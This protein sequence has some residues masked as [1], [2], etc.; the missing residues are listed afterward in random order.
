MCFRKLIVN[1]TITLSGSFSFQGDRAAQQWIDGSPYAFQMW[2]S[3]DPHARGKIYTT[4]IFT[5]NNSHSWW[6]YEAAISR[7]NNHYIEPDPAY[8]C[9][10]AQ[11]DA[12]GIVK[13][14]KLPCDFSLE[15]SAHFCELKVNLNKHRSLK[16]WKYKE[17]RRQCPPR[18]IKLL[19]SCI[20]IYTLPSSSKINLATFCTV[21]GGKLYNMPNFLESKQP[22]DWNNYEN[23]II[24]VLQAMNH[25]WPIFPHYTETSKDQ[26]IAV[27]ENSTKPVVLQFSHTALSQVEIVD[28]HTALKSGGIHVA[29][30]FPLLL[31]NS[32]CLTG[33]FACFDGT[34]IL[35][36]YVCDGVND[37]PD[38]SD[39]TDCEY[40]CSFFDIASGEK[41][42]CFASCF[43][44]NCICTDLY[45]QCPS[46]GCVPWSRICDGTD[47]CPSAE[48]EQ[49][50]EFNFMD[51]PN[52]QTIVQKRDGLHISGRREIK[53]EKYKCQDNK[54][55]LVTMLNDLVP[56]CLD[57]VDE[58][59]FYNFLINGSQTTYSADPS[60]C[61]K[62]D[63]TTCV[64]NYPDVCYPR[65]LHCV[66]ELR[67]S[68]A[69]GCRNAGHMLNCEHHDCPSQFKCPGAYC[70]P[71]HNVCDG[72]QDCPNGEDEVQCHNISC[73]GL[74]L[75]RHDNVCVHPYDIWQGHVKCPKSE[76][77]KALR[78][79]R[80][81]SPCICLGYAMLCESSKLEYLPK[82]SMCLRVLV[83]K[84]IPINMNNIKFQES[85]FVFLLR[86]RITNASVARLE[87]RHIDRLT[88]L[89]NLNLSHNSILRLNPGTFKTLT[90]LLSIDLSFNA[91]SILQSHM[92]D[93]AQMVTHLTLANN[94]IRLIS[95]RT[96]QSLSQLQQLK[97]S[98]NK[99]T[100]LG[101]NI[102]CS[103]SLKVV[104]ISYN[105]FSKIDED[106]LIG[107]FQHLKVLNTS[108]RRI[109]CGVSSGLHCYPK[110]VLS[111]ISS[112]SHLVASITTRAILWFVGAAL[113]PLLGIC[114]AWFVYQIR[115][116][117]NNLYNILSSLNFG[118]NLYICVYCFIISFVDHV[119]KG[120]YFFF[121][122]V[123]RQ[124]TACILLNCLSYSFFQTMA[125]LCT[126]ISCIRTIAILYPFKAPEISV[127]GT[128]IAV[129]LWF[130]I[131]IIVSYSCLTWVWPG[132]YKISETAVGLA[133]V[134]PG[135]GHE[136]VNVQWH[137]LLFIVPSVLVLFCF[138]CTQGIGIKGLM[139][140]SDTGATEIARRNRR[141]ASRT[142]LVTLILTLVQ[143]CPLLL[144][145]ILA[146]FGVTVQPNISFF[147]TITTLFLIPLINVIL[148]VVISGAFQDFILRRCLK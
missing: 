31:S 141:R 37:C 58:E 54:T 48:D 138:C 5:R 59:R 43:I 121:D 49:V 97:L 40:V 53:E 95:R 72:K 129:M 28:M 69:V 76:D 102:L 98:N 61:N 91:L 50:C 7:G 67:G 124:S 134:L 73:P 119:Y 115:T 105:I 96:F 6:N 52:K 100:Q 80:C 104:D 47:D 21:R 114:V 77:D 39:E 110:V 113:L 130:V 78:Y 89:Q 81:P 103:P 117:D 45:Y 27:R 20:G 94:N 38:S 2:H 132:F 137:M 19:P 87:P 14:I 88:F 116:S 147:F 107:S 92:F 30:E 56:D 148:H 51:S 60:L 33:H 108:P 10:A 16:T 23:Y 85:N 111:K 145:H 127:W 18:T 99:I 84:D 131:C 29:C 112:C 125:F 41:Q 90:N 17:N 55:V 66:Y 106:V 135:I 140:E 11:I 120:H 144:M 3:P 122:E 35:E 25:R 13:W 8:A 79:A 44:D 26:L 63:E 71:V 36:H 1:Y 15:H 65:H 118:T 123:W 136:K 57:H 64:K 93:G 101:E 62:P 75:C 74:L 4:T 82:L 142:S 109:C 24:N 126:L 146:V 143:F 68:V 22:F 128:L 139:K 133:L 70:I 86:L 12:Q 46:G 83:V 32:S 42:N 9:T 34:C